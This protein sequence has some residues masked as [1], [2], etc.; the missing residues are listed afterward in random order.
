MLL[1]KT[2]NSVF[3]AQ[4]LTMNIF[5]KSYTMIICFLKKIIFAKLSDT[6]EWPFKF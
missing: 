3:W 6:I 4:I 5:L 2:A 1:K